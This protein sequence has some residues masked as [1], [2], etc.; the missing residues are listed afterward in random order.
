M[1]EFDSTISG[2]PC[3]IRITYWERHQSAILRADPGDSHPEEG[4]CGNW[5]ICDRKGRLA[6]WLE[7]KITG[8]DLARIEHEVFNHMENQNDYDN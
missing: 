7:R 6:P 5:E 4:G 2:I 3:K 1:S 8:Q